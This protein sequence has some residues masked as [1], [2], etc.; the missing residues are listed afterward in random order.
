[1]ANLTN[2]ANKYPSQQLVSPVASNW[3][4]NSPPQIVDVGDET[5]YL[6][7]YNWGLFNMNKGRDFIET[8]ITIHPG[9]TALAQI[10]I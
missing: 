7:P 9:W 3:Q 2:P 4:T 10:K 6:G 5:T 8:C 1:M